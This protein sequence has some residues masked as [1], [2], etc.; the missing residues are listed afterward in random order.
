M[1]RLIATAQEN[2][3]KMKAGTYRFPDDD[4]FVV[5]RGGGPRLM[6][7]DP[8]IHH[9]TLKPVKLLKNDGSVVTQIVESVRPVAKNAV[10]W[11]A[12]FRDGTLFLTLRSFLSA[13]AVR[14]T[15]AM[16][17]IDAC[18]SN[19]S[20][21]CALKNIQVPILL[22][23]MQGHYFLRDNEIQFE[24]AASKDKELIVVEGASHG[25]TPCTECETTPGQYS[26]SVKN[27]FDYVQKWIDARF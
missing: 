22:A 15:D 10:A 24:A 11:N 12:S 6:E 13:N 19:N 26:N 25:I 1:N 27:F 18:S 7:L 14:S 8:S 3:K 20:T 21:I 9:S 16:E 23:T 17:G 4:A 5:V 2:V